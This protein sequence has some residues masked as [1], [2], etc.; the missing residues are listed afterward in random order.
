ML[1]GIDLYDAMGQ[2]HHL[3]QSLVVSERCSDW[4]NWL[5]S[6]RRI[7]VFHHTNIIY[8]NV[9]DVLFKMV[10][11]R[12]LPTNYESLSFLFDT[13]FSD[14]C[15]W[16]FN[17][18]WMVSSAASYKDFLH[19]MHFVLVIVCDPNNLVCGRCIYRETLQG[20]IDGYFSSVD[21]FM[22]C[23]C[24]RITSS[25]VHIN[26]ATSLEIFP[27][28][29]LPIEEM[30]FFFITNIIVALGSHAFDK[31]KAIVDTY[32]CDPFEIGESVSPLKRLI[33]NARIM[34]RSSTCNDHTFDLSVV[35]D[36]KTC[37]VVLNRAS[38]SFS[39]AANC[40]PNGEIKKNIFSNF[41]YL[42]PYSSWF[43]EIDMLIFFCM[44]RYQ[45]GFNNFV[46]LLSCYG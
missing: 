22:L 6:N 29:D 5:R 27:V 7:H 14:L 28:D 39:L 43:M 16:H 30:I 37:I 33:E 8:G 41:S 26:E 32:H 23:G 45:T 31:C 17:D 46:R 35:D 15:W 3:S 18:I 21:L 9:D 13:I 11:E 38:K 10:D 2:L 4:N 34:I 12:S 1:V 42:S 20:N 44:R 36:L 24:N 40:F 25:C 19:W